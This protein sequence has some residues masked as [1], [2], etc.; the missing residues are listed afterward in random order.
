MT[1]DHKPLPILGDKS[2]ADIPNPRLYRFKER[3]MRYRFQIQYLPGDKNNT[4]DT[5]SRLHENNGKSPKPEEELETNILVVTIKDG[6]PSRKELCSQVLMPFHKNREGL[7]WS[8]W[9]VRRSSL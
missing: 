8:I 4:P 3:S 6:F 9:T 7:A 5:M 2:L 1:V